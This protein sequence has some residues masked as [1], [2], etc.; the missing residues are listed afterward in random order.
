M[1]DISVQHKADST[2][3]QPRRLGH[4]NLF[5]SD[6][7]RSADFYKS[8]VGFEE[9]YRQPDNKASFLSNGNTYHDLALTST[10]SKYATK[11]QKPGLFHLAF[12]LETEK[13]L[14]DGYNR[15]REAG[16]DFAFV[17]D[18]DVA[19]SVYMND[20][21]GN[22]VEIYADVEADWRAL[23]QG[24]IVKEKPKWIPGV[25]SVPL[26]EKNYPQNPELVKVEPATFHS[27]KV[28]HIGLVANDFEK[29]YDYYVD[30]I[31]LTPLVGDRRSAF[32]VLQGTASGG[33]VTLYR[34]SSNAAP[35][36]H[37][38]GFEVWDEDDLRRSVEAAAK[39]GIAI[40]RNIDH[41]ARHSIMIE[42]PDGLKLQ[43]FVNRDWTAD[44]IAKVDPKEALDLL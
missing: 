22:M 10:Q 3:F 11:D 27:R 25:T 7:E 35:G 1:V 4:A 38:V 28:T 36:L 16:I 8:V 9:V 29:M 19:R 6:Y 30:V 34:K 14:V 26:T 18:H 23:R 32:A 43:F 44:V 24:I 5:V 2:Y 37:H 42:D 20:P 41:P 40:K 39:Q 13:D 15:A 17:M 33:D 21:D 31:G 12:E